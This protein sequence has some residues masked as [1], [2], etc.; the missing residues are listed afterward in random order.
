MIS[1][2]IDLEVLR[3]LDEET[4]VSGMAR[5]FMINRAC[6]DYL[7]LIDIIRSC[8][9]LHVNIKDDTAFNNWLTMVQMKRHHAYYI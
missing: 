5:N 7:H 6:A 2:R 8:Q 9:A 3:L 4:K 1:V